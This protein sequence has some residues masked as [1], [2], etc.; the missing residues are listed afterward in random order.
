MPRCF[1]NPGFQKGL[2]IA[3]CVILSLFLLALCLFTGFVNYTLNHM[4]QI[5]PDKEVT[6][7]PSEADGLDYDDNLQTI[8]P[9]STDD[10]IH[11]DDITLPQYT[12]GNGQGGNNVQPMPEL[13]VITGKHLVNILLV[14]QD[15]REGQ[16]RQRSDSMILVTFNKSTNRI[17]LTSFMRDQYVQ[18]PGYKNNK[19]NAAYEIGGMKLL[20][21]TMKAN[22]G[23]VV[24][25]IVEVD[26]SGF[27]KVVD[28]V[29]GV[30]IELTE[31]EAE[32]LNASVGGHWSLVAGQQLLNG[33]QALA[34]SRI[35]S[36]DT[37]YR[38]AERQR[39]VV[40]A[41][42]NGA[43]DL[44]LGELFTLMD[45]ILPLVSTNLSNSKIMSYASDLFP[46]LSSAKIKTARIPVDGTFEYGIVEVRDG[47]T[48]WFQYNI[49][50]Y[51]NNQY[52]NDIFRKKG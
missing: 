16:G 45:D 33:E 26:F 38:R 52:L 35:R 3:L 32:Y 13:E 24:D 19:L 42:I 37:D 7:S 47:L 15:R 31:K 17:T 14:G 4:N 5:D 44:S 28:L 9:D 23:V 27:T 2:L 12:E 30:N 25:G 22:F 46:M 29:G 21:K 48:A 20:T 50:F 34:Y 49:D 41:I 51:A 8:D 43:K 10:I 36:I 1:S 6:L 11:I 40:T 39:N 18:I